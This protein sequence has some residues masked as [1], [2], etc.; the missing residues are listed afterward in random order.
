MK[1]HQSGLFL[2]R[3]TLPGSHPDKEN[4]E[5]QENSYYQQYQ[6]YPGG[7]T[8]GF[9]DGVRMSMAFHVQVL[10]KVVVGMSMAVVT[11]PLFF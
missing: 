7:K 6:L 3:K 11:V 10:L 4:K 8:A 2:V 9:K 1:T 5:D